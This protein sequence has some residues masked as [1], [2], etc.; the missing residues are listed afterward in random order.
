[1]TAFEIRSIV[2]ACDAAADMSLAV[3]DAAALAARWGATL[4][5]IFFEDENLHRLA[6]L[7]IVAHIG[8][9]RDQSAN[10]LTGEA[11]QELLKLSSGGMRRAIEAAAV[12]HGLSWSFKTLRLSPASS[13][14]A[15]D[16]DIVI[17]EASARPF[18]GGWRPRSPWL[19]AALEAPTTTLLRRRRDGHG[20][21][22]VL[23]EE[24]AAREQIVRAALAFADSGEPVVVLSSDPRAAEMIPP[25]QLRRQ[26][27]VE[28]LAPDRADLTARLARLD[29]ALLVVSADES[30]LA[31]RQIAETSE[32]DLLI[33]K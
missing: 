7:E 9:A 10:A 25:D 15:L 27:R 11:L 33:V 16:G 1:M 6:E 3:A 30:A 29:P 2:I 28:T 20:V 32:C 26:L 12:E 13:W 14:P 22:I 23:P 4:N 24:A 31:L 19:A 5:G 18:A 21:A 8:L 17:V